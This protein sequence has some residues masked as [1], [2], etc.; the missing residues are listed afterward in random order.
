MRIYVLHCMFSSGEL[1]IRSREGYCGA[2]FLCCTAAKE[3]N[4]QITL[5]WAYK[6]LLTI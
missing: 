6:Q 4:T 1:F 2:Y 5:E 3:I